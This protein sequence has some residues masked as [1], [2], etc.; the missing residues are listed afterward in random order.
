MGK[1]VNSLLW[2]S[3]DGLKLETIRLSLDAIAAWWAAKADT[4]KAPKD[5]NAFW[6]VGV[7]F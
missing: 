2:S 1:R 6:A 3:G 7:T 5:S 4:I